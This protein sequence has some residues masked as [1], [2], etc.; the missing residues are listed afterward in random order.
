MRSVVICLVCTLL[1][2]CASTSGVQKMGPDT[3][4]T[5]AS[6]SPARGGTSGARGMALT[7]ANEY[8]TQMSKDIFVTNITSETTNIHGA[9]S[10]AVTFR[11]L[12]KGDPE[13]QRPEYRQVPDT[14]IEDR[15]E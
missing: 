9:G 5:S 1:T 12:A 7:E 6:A 2:A 8:C 10:A 13:L 11:C 3:Y 14:V 4:S 15:R